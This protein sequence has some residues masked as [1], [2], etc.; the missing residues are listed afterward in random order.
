MEVLIPFVVVALIYG[1]T[2]LVLST[3]DRVWAKQAEVAK[4]KEE[5]FNSLS[6]EQHRDEAEKALAL[7]VVHS[8]EGE[9]Y[10][11]AYKAHA[12][13]ARILDHKNLTDFT[14]LK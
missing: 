3:Q 4:Q 14:K 2:F 9:K 8:T 5:W 7:S 11:R 1:L 6:P 13:K 12:A 10:L